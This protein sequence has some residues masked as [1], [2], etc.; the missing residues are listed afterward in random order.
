MKTYLIRVVFGSAIIPFA[1][2]ADT[3]FAQSRDAEFEEMK[4]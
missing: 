4:L 2:L 1:I 3:A